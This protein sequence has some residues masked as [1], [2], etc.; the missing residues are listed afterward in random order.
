MSE[1]FC[2]VYQNRKFA[3]KTY[4]SEEEFK[5]DIEKKIIYA[6]CPS[7]KYAETESRKLNKTLTKIREKGM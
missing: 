3:A 2:V 6:R 1:M 7:F 5:K 4:L